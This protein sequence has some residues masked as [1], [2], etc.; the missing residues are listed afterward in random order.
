LPSLLC[1]CVF[2]HFFSP[3]TLLLG[4]VVGEGVPV[5]ATSEVLLVLQLLR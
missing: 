1:L 2:I 5:N 3:S 4:R